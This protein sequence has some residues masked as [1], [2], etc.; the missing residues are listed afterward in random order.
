MCARGSDDESSD[1]EY[2]VAAVLARR[3]RT[4]RSKW[5]YL[6]RWKG[7]DPSHDTWEPATHVLADI[8]DNLPE[9]KYKDDDD[10]DDVD[11]DYTASQTKKKKQA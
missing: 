1:E 5:E 11:D 10:D 8:P 9:R 6:I 7:Y 2:E 4:P 3:R